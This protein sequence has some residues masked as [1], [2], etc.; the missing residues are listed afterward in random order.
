MFS[1][2]QRHKVIYQY[3]DLQKKTLTFFPQTE[4][5]VDILT[6]V[7]Q[8]LEKDD[9]FLVDLIANKGKQLIINFFCFFPSY[10]DHGE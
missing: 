10:F 9:L 6:S 5:C 3:A 8:C 4:I 2:V 1:D 7:S